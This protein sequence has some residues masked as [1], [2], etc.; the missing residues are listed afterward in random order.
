MAYRVELIFDVAAF[1]VAASAAEMPANWAQWWW[2]RFNSWGRLSA[3]FGG[4]IIPALVWFVPPT[5]HWPWWDRTYLVI[6]LNSGLSLLV[7][8]LTPPDRLPIL[9]RFYE[10]AR[11]LGAW[12]IVRKQIASRA[13]A[14]ARQRSSR[15]RLWADS[16]AESRW[17]CSEPCR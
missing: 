14:N 8:L 1:M 12:G 5:S 17:P 4:L 6:G 9:S 7:T 11:P 15:F 3:S 2:W 16:A 13:G 10:A